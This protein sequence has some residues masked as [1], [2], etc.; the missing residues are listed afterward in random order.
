[1][2]L[3]VKAVRLTKTGT[4]VNDL[5]QPSCKKRGPCIAPNSRNG[6]RLRF[7]RG[8]SSAGRALRSQCRGREFDPPPLHHHTNARRSP[9]T[10]SSCEIANVCRFSWRAAKAAPFPTSQNSQVLLL[11][12]RCALHLR[13]GRLSHKVQRL[14]TIGKSIL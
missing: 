7:R 14:L 13:K 9:G 11:L 1:M 2:G 8:G 4:G 10:V 3:D 12:V 5:N 6:A